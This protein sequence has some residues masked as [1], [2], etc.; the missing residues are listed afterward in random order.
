MEHQEWLNWR[1]SGI[2]SSDAAVIMGVSPWKTLFELYEEKTIG[3]EIIRDN[4]A[5]KRG[6]DIEDKAR[7]AFENE[8][9]TCLFPERRTHSTYDW[10][11]ATLDG[12][13]VDGK[14][15]V[16]IKCP[17]KEDHLSAI[18]GKIPEKYYPQCQH[19]LLVTGLDKMYYYSFDGERGISVEVKRDDPYLDELFK[20]ETDF[21]KAVT[22]RIPPK[23]SEKDCLNLSEDWIWE[24]YEEQMAK[25]LE[26]IKLLEE[27]KEELKE[28]LISLSGERN[29]YGNRIKLTKTICKGNVDYQV[30]IA[31]YLEKLKSNY[32][33]IAFPHLDLDLY[34]KDSFTKWNIRAI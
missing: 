24:T 11:R 25:T 14:V 29:A 19:Q 6:R 10:L 3:K 1:R 2:G 21:W 15:L 13:S 4:S 23:L 32:P 34:R 26:G 33:T 5:M 31:E 28:R 18:E 8:V 9:G 16:E 17:G 7:C 30:A 20:K 27:Q 22:E 12:I